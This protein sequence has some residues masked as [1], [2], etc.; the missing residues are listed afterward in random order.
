MIPGPRRRRRREVAAAVGVLTAAGV[1]VAITGPFRAA[2]ARGSG[3]PGDAGPVGLYTVVRRDLASQTQVPATLGYVGSFTIA[4]PSGSS[5]QQVAQAR[6]AVAQDRQALFAD[7]QAESDR[8]T[9]DQRAVAAAQTAVDTASGRPQLAQ[10]QQQLAAA[11]SSA[12]ADHDQGQAKVAADEIKLD[13]D[14]TALASLEATEVNPGTVF[15]ALPSVGEVITQNEP[16][17]SLS[18]QPVQLLYGSTP[19]YRA[20]YV[21]MSDGVD[22]GELTSD[23]LALG[24][25]AGLAQ[26]NNY[27]PATAVAVKRWQSAL[28]LPATGQI[29]LGQILFEP[30]PVRVTSVTPS[31]GDPTTGGG[32]AGS[33]LSATFTTRQISIALDASN[34]SEVAVGDRVS[35]TLPNNDTTPGVISSV[36]TVATAPAANGPS[37]GNA[38]SSGPTITVLVRP[39]NPAA[40][41][42][43]DQ[44]P[45]NV[46]IDTGTVTNA[47]VVPVDA[48]L[49]Q[50]GGGYAV[51]E[52]EDNGVHRLLPVELGLFDDA[53]GLVQVT[54]SG[55]TAGEQV[56][57]PHL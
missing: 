13:G 49:A 23:L 15:T 10:A 29:L 41:G 54:G 43:W 27:S 56:V 47:L 14:Q 36:G 6:Q 8:A 55:L 31:L 40:T 44:A 7:E 48:L 33:V 34:Q 51:E 28:G 3:Q 35:I 17:Y 37:G 38:G 30:G 5:T 4:L 22:V 11:Q 12:T 46:N 25:G 18:G 26:S 42:T 45:V 50:T 9:A 32:G 19:A 24:Y 53:A 39:T 1:A 16:L 52:V 20:F 2:A 21:G 57:V